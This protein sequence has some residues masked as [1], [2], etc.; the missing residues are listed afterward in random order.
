MTDAE[1]QTEIQLGFDELTRILGHP[2]TCSAAPGWVCTERVLAIKARFPFQYNSDCR[3]DIPFR[4]V[5]GGRELP[6][7]QVP[8]S[9]PTYDELL[10]RGGITGATY[11]DRLLS[12]FSTERVNVLAVHAEV[13]GIARAKMF[14]SFLASAAARGIRFVP[15]GE[16]I[17]ETAGLPIGSV[18]ERAI[19]GRQ[20]SVACQSAGVAGR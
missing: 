4:P 7:V 6:Q 12:L 14:D 19:P 9:L 1:I 13:E 20:G 15:L 16:L 11:Q 3:G 17:D 2:P 10:G 5:V 8:V 18:V